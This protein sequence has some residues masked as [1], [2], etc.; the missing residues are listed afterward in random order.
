ML[1][2]GLMRQGGRYDLFGWEEGCMRPS[3]RQR[4]GPA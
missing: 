2:F 3:G 1:V 4:A